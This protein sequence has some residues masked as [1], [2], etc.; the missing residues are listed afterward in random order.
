MCEDFVRDLQG[1]HKG[2]ASKG[3]FCPGPRSYPQMRGLSISGLPF[4][5]LLFGPGSGLNESPRRG[6]FGAAG[7][8][9][10]NIFG[11]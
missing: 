3:I 11:D 9:E 6:M 4:G 1:V 8:G 5:L 7:T 2:S 10:L